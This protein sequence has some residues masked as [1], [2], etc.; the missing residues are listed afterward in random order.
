MSE[1]AITIF[2]PHRNNWSLVMFKQTARKWKPFFNSLPSLYLQIPPSHFLTHGFICC[3][4]L[5]LNLD[6]LL[7]PFNW[8][9]GGSHTDDTGTLDKLLSLEKV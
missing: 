7:Q 1:H 9:F 2:L 5:D 3:P 4:H 6:T 8:M